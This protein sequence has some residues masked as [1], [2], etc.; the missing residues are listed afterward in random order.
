[1]KQW[2]TP[3]TLDDDAPITAASAYNLADDITAAVG[4]LQT[5][6]TKTWFGGSGNNVRDKQTQI[7]A[8]DRHGPGFVGFYLDLYSTIAGEIPLMLAHTP[9]GATTPERFEGGRANALLAGIR[10]VDIDQQ[11]FHQQNCRQM[12]AVG[13]IALWPHKQGPASGWHTALPHIVGSHGKHPTKK[14]LPAAY[15]VP[16]VEKGNVKDGTAIRVPY[17][18]MR[19]IWRPDITYR[20]DAYSPLFR[21]LNDIRRFQTLNRGIQR[22]AAALIILQGLLWIEG[23]ASDVVPQPDKQTGNAN[24][25]LGPLGKQIQSLLKSAQRNSDD[26]D[27]KLAASAFPHPFVY[28]NEPKH[29]E[30]GSAIPE[31]VLEGKRDALEDSARGVSGPMSAIVDGQGAAQRLLNEWRQETAVMQAAANLSRRVASGYTKAILSK[32]LTEDEQARAV[33]VTVDMASVQIQE[34]DTSE[35]ITLFERGIIDRS[36]LARRLNIDAGS[37]LELPDG[38]SEYEHWLASRAPATIASSPWGVGRIVEDTVEEGDEGDLRRPS[39]RQRSDVAA[40]ASS[41]LD[42]FYPDNQ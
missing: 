1:M 34:P 38:V 6:K 41:W 30:F 2:F 14:G 3:T 5:T 16:L 10:G 29:I 27:E 40:A 11:E 22:R 31:R 19:R 23:D 35:E 25:R 17:D 42:D 24:K 32:Q 7:V 28:G 20:L 21:I 15:D 8:Y 26:V 36:E 33:H 13:E 12:E 37:L 9:D 18:H 39:E 4:P